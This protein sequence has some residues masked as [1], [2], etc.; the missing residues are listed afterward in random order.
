MTVCFPRAG[1]LALESRHARGFVMQPTKHDYLK[2]LLVFSGEGTLLGQG[3]E[4]PLK[5][6]DVVVIPPGCEHWIEDR[7]PLSL[8]VLCFR[9]ADFSVGWNG[10]CKS[11]RPRVHAGFDEILDPT[12]RLL[13]EQLSARPACDAM[14]RG[15]GWQM[16]AMLARTADDEPAVAKND[17]T[18]SRARVAEAARELHFRFYEPLRID[19][20]ARRAKLGRRRFTQLFRE[21]NGLTWWEALN[22]AR[23]SHAERLLRD[24][25]RSVTAVAF[26]CGYGDLSGFYRAWGGRHPTSPQEWRLRGRARVP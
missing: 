1:I 24:T 11:G 6:G 18:G 14:A 16:L 10:I 25:N 8:Y 20:V 7:Q 3:W 2:A 15:L 4:Q 23:L 22:V 19:D 5:V 12:R 26:E 9:S 21:V 13:Y 17:P